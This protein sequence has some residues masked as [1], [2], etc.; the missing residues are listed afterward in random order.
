MSFRDGK[1]RFPFNLRQIPEESGRVESGFVDEQYRQA[2]PHRIYALARRAFQGLGRGLK[3][4]W[5][6]ASRTHQKVE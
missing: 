5:F 1:G 6:L 3:L 2:V 4:E